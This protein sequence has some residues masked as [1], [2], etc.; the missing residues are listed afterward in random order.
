MGAN[1]TNAEGPACIA[2]TMADQGE[3]HSMREF[4]APRETLIIEIKITEVGGTSGCPQINP[5]RIGKGAELGHY[6]TLEVTHEVSYNA[7]A[8]FILR[9]DQSELGPLYGRK[10]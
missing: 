3:V 2:Y 9:K 4:C 1:W 10:I 8:A 5:G 6:H 7:T